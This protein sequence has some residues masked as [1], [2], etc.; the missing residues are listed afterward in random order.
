MK[1]VSICIPVY[2][3]A[4]SLPIA[5]AEIERLFSETIK[6]YSFEI[7]ITDNGSSDSTWNIIEGLSREKS[8]IKGYRFSRNFGYQNSIF[9]G[10]C[11][12]SGDAVIEIDADLEDPPSVIPEFI[13]KWEQGY[14]VVYGVRRT[15]H[16]G[17][18]LRA[19]FKI[20]YW[21]L[22][23]LSEF[24]IPANAGDFRL[25]DRK[26]VTV[27]K[28][29]PE[30]NLYLRGLVTFL[31]FSQV[32][33]YYD[34]NPR[35]HGDSKFKFVQYLVFAIDAITAFTK[36]PLRFMGVAGVILFAI[37]AF[38]SSYYLVMYFVKGVAVQGFT[39]LVILI[40]F[41]NSINFMFLG[42]IGEY[43]SRIFDDSK[44]RPR[45]I[46]EKAVNDQD[47]PKFM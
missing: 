29:L 23:R 1:I 25:I 28:S 2:N 11:L 45:V 39:T 42:T 16:I 33:V 14:D 36:T 38:M 31:G 4:E 18:F 3:E 9:A 43:L 12:A 40:L 8:Y 21:V 32:A 47:F 24:E 27:L 19:I 15:R 30:R 10:M 35:L 26:V 6:G 37:T 20:F 34:R 5:V 22:N 44:K 17:I 41:L 7:I 13:S 46:I